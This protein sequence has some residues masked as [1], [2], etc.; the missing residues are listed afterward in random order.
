MAFRAS[1]IPNLLSCSH[2]LCFSFSAHN[3]FT[4][5]MNASVGIK[6]VL[7]QATWREAKSILLPFQFSLSSIF[8]L[9]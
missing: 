8:A 2:L 3:E 7:Y 6:H 9:I 4:S 5:V 1:Y